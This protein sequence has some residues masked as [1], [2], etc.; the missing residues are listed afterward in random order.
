MT[1][2]T[3]A[4]GKHSTKPLEYSIFLIGKSLGQGI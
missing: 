3:D 4:G 1:E 2:V